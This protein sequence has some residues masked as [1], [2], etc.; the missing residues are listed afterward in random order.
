M[1]PDEEEERRR[2]PEPDYDNLEDLDIQTVP[3]NF[4][5]ELIQEIIKVDPNLKVYLDALP[6]LVI[7]GV[8]LVK[9]T[10]GQVED[11]GESEDVRR[12]CELDL[13]ILHPNG[14]DCE[15]KG[16]QTFFREVS[17]RD[18]VRFRFYYFPEEEPEA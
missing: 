8:K 15:Q 17:P 7:Q 13:K 18:L 9:I 2:S 6:D 14:D 5:T 3:L 1:G 10:E 12:F 11:A 4:P 16:G